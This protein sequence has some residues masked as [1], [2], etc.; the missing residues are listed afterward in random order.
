MT[1]KNLEGQSE[2]CVPNFLKDK[3]SFDALGGCI[4]YPKTS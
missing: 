1:V 4:F 3:I 2:F